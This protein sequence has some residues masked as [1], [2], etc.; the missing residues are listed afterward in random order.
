MGA[1]MFNY[2]IMFE[3]KKRSQVIATFGFIMQFVDYPFKA[4]APLT[5]SIN[6]LVMED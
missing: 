4:S 5:I 6:S 3:N 1:K 2:R